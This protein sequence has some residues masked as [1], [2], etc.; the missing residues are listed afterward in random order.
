MLSS[1]PFPHSPS[2]RWSLAGPAPP[3]LTQDTSPFG[4]GKGGRETSTA[5]PTTR[6]E[7]GS[8]PGPLHIAG[9]RPRGS[10]DRSV[11]GGREGR[12]EW[13]VFLLTVCAQAGCVCLCAGWLRGE[14]ESD[15][16][17]H[18]TA[19]N[20]SIYVYAYKAFSWVK[21][22]SKLKYTSILFCPQSLH[23]YQRL[24]NTVVEAW[25]MLGKVGSRMLFSW[26]VRPETI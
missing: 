4:S 22:K 14:E 17:G 3:R 5:P 10:S 24:V 2:N 15:V 6:E 13:V 18:Q 12:E 16:I 9:P 1:P 21:Q 7:Q 20:I 23:F 26:T 11:P 8:A 19:R 25:C